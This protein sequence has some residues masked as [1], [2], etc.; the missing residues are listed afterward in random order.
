MTALVVSGLDGALLTP[1]EQI[2]R[3]C[4]M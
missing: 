3:G 1:E 4:L 2:T